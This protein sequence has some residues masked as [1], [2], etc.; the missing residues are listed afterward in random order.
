MDG[1][2]KSGAGHATAVGLDRPSPYRIPVDPDVL[3]ATAIEPGNAVALELTVTDRFP[4]L[5]CTPVEGGGGGAVTRTL[6]ARSGEDRPHLTLPKAAIEAGGFV[7]RRAL[8]YAEADGERLFVGLDRPSGIDGVALTAT[9]TARL[10]RYRGGELVVSVGESVAGPLG[11]AEALAC[12]FDHTDGQPVFVFGVPA[13][14]PEGAIE[15][16]ANPNTGREDQPGLSVYFPRLLGRLCAVTGSRF[17]WGRTAD[18]N[19]LLGV[20]VDG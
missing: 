3:A 15:R 16:T 18:G 8:A 20:P 4:R 2:R 12:W 17:R 10:S 5:A 6:D 11:A 13:V 14:A 9:E 19:R 1:E 7:G